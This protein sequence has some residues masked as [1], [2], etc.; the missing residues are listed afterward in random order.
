M[1][2]SKRLLPLIIAESLLAAGCGGGNAPSPPPQMPSG[3]GQLIQSPPVKLSSLSASDLLSALSSSRQGQVLLQFALSP[4]CSV[5]TYHLEYQTVGA[6]D[7]AA[8]ASAALMIPTGSDPICQAPH[9]I[10]LYAHGKRTLKSFNIADLTTQSWESLALAAVAGARGYIVV[11]PNYAGYDTS[12]LDYHPYL[13][14]NQQSDDMIDALTAARSALSAM[15]QADNHQLFVTGYSQGGYVA[16]ATHRA[17]Q[18]AGIPVTASAPMSGPYALSAFGDAVFMGQVDDGAAQ[19]FIMVASSYQHAYSNLYSDPTEVFEPAYASGIDSLL[20]NATDVS[21]LIAQGR[22]PQSALFSNSPPAPEFA[23]ITPATTPAQLAV[24]FAAGFGTGNLVTNAY[25]LSYL[26]DAQAEPDG[27]FPSD[28]T[29]VP[30]VSPANA[31]RQDLKTNDLRNWAPNAPVLLC[32]GNADPS[33][34]YFNTRLMQEFWATKAPASRVTVLDVDSPVSSGDPYASV[35]TTFAAAK[36]A[37]AAAAVAAGATDGG[38]A[39]VLQVYH[40]DLVP[41][42]CLVAAASFFENY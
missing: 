37:I 32:A 25:R 5:D 11:A 6:R 9:P 27:G 36:S 12:N 14:A 1:F 21:T 3:R 23:S 26:R 38:A 24:V 30:P 22:L 2:P 34:F 16:M 40:A 7:E 39:A 33:V 4:T 28:T 19:D 15:N 31:L 20:P 42:F 35:K 8:T 41:P 18:A 13:N 29:G 10:V 17:L